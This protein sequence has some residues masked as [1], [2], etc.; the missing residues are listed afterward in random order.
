MSR[1][2]VMVAGLVLVTTVGATS[3]AHFALIRSTPAKDQKIEATTAPTRLQLWFS[4]VPAAP[5]SHLALKREAT[6]VALGKFVV[7]E[8]D[9]SLYADSAKPLEAGTYTL[10]WRAAGDDGH[11]MSGEVKFSIVPKSTR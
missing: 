11:V 9:K 6:D 2:A 5:A 4:E 10:T 7:V 8:K 3:K 1:L